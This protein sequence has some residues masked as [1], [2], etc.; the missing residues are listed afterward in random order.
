MY[1]IC[2]MPKFIAVTLTFYSR[3]QFQISNEIFIQT[4]GSAKN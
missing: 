2:V 1:N 3:T 4:P